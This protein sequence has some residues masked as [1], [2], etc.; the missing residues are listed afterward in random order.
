ML[1]DIING[2]KAAGVPSFVIAI[3]AVVGV[4]WLLLERVK[5]TR[6]HRK[7]DRELLSLDEHKFREAL[8]KELADLREE[9]RG[10]RN[11]LINCHQHHADLQE[12]VSRIIVATQA[13]AVQLAMDMSE[14]API[15]PAAA[16][17][18]RA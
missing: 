14:V 2:L 11:D 9:Q 13:S 5:A 18:A 17:E 10:L 12:R 3:F 15:A 8:M 7:S 16:K 6:G 1:A 4:V